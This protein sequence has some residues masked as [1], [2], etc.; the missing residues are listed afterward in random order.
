M[1]NNHQGSVDHG[2]KIIRAMARV[3]R[4]NGI[5]GAVKLQ[6][7]DLDTFI[8]PEARKDESVKHVSRFMG[9]RLSQTEF[10]S[11]IDEMREFG[12]IPV[13]TPFDEV[14]VGRAV[15][16]GVQIMKV[17]SCSAN[18]WPLLEAIAE[19]RLPVIASTGGLSIY[20]IDKLVSFFT[21]K[22][23][24]FAI[25]HCVAVY[26]TPHE[27]LGLNF[28]EKLRRRYPYVPIGYSGHEPPENL[29]AG[30][31]AV[32]KGARL[33]ERHVG[34]PTEQI[35]LNRYSMSPEQTDAWVK[36]VLAARQMCGD[37]DEKQI[38]QDEIDS[39]M[40]LKRGVYAKRPIKA[41]EALS[42]EDVYF[43]M[44]A[45]EG[46]TTSGNF[47]E[48]RASWS[49]SRDYE[50]DQPVMERRQPD[51]ISM[52]R[53]I[54]HDVKGMFYEAQ[55]SL[56]EDFTIELSHHEGIEHFRQTGA[57]ICNIM[58]REYC[59]KLI[60]MLAGQKHPNHRHTKKEE[61]FQVLWGELEV[62]RNNDE[63]FHLK[64]GDQLLIERNS[65]HRFTT[66]RGVIFEEISTTH[67]KNDSHYED[68]RISALDPMERK[69]VIEDW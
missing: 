32:S 21:H 45:L 14:S 24:E 61:T 10:R 54:M 63:V 50:V 7:R 9:T 65:W 12:L 58:N 64:A 19:T 69:T 67:F 43:A 31:V 60:A 23:T 35:T 39:L 62:T 52:I 68:E 30:Q 11:L 33:L 56:G 42:A 5:K 18:D 6:Y 4:E 25:M 57:L 47:G 48:Y 34:L 46:Q 36:G 28:V 38:G 16:H 15:D 1:A 53:G 40:S 27:R 51:T 26:P 8:H 22:K 20:D 29:A 66:P 55:I 17:A 13:V 49:A 3:A 59:K 2:L 41:G 37:G 44:P